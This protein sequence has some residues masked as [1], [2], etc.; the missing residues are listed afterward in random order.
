MTYS[1]VALDARSGEFGVAV[2][3]HYFAVGAAVMWASPG[4]GAVATQ[5]TIKISHGPR[6][7]ELL[8]GG[9]DAQAA[10][11]RLIGGDEE[12]ATRQLAIVDAAGNTAVHTGGSCVR[13]AGYVARDGVSCQANIVA[14]DGVWSAMLDSFESAPGSLHHRLL[15]AL[16]AGEAEGGD[17]RG[18]QSAAILVVPAAGERWDYTISVR[19][20]D[21]PEP[22]LE[23]R[24][25]V[26]LH[27]A[28]KLATEANGL[29]DA[30]DHA[31]AT[32]LFERA[33]ELAPESHDLLF[34]AGLSFALMGDLDGGV[35]RVRRAIEM[36]PNWKKMLD[37]LPTA[38]AP[39]AAKLIA[40]LNA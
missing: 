3:S 13:E 17:L 26:A 34:R 24:R 33:C 14:S 30:G 16:D 39:V 28:Y 10:L 27:D 40:R 5:A 1:I 11:E 19:V 37:R 6:A 18:R 20:D 25:L 9:F 32:V 36:Q 22:L 7:L 4:V 15:A 23:L 21:H 31:E 29:L 8:Q 12:A 2:Q 35:R 38:I